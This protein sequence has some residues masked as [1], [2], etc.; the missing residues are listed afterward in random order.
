MRAGS[1]REGPW[2]LHPPGVPTRM[3]QK[4]PQI[5]LGRGLAVA[6]ALDLL[7]PRFPI[8]GGAV[9]ASRAWR[10]WGDRAYLTVSTEDGKTGLG[11]WK[12]PAPQP[13]APTS[14]SGQE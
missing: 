9:L 12:T 2:E 8:A 3:R 11:L 14:E 10:V 1:L 13:Q 5:Q 6:F 4:M 7:P